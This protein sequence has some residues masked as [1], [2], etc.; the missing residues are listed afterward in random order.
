MKNRIN[1]VHIRTKVPTIIPTEAVQ[2]G[3]TK[4]VQEIQLP[5]SLKDYSVELQSILYTTFIFSP[6][7]TEVIIFIMQL[8]VSPISVFKMA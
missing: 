4:S 3:E 7:N 6:S 5:C 1:S 8:C 2:E